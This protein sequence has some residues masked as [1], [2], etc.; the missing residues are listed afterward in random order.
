MSRRRYAVVGSGVSGLV[1]A[2]VLSRTGDVTLFEADARL[3]GHADTHDVEVGGRMLAVDTGFIVHN[4]RTYP[5]L[6]RLFAELG[7]ATQETDMSMSVRSDADGIEYAGGRGLSGILPSARLIGRPRYLRMLGEVSRFHRAAKA[8]LAQGDSGADLAAFLDEHS[9]SADF[10]RWFMT[11]LVAAVWS[12]DPADAGDYPAR[13]LFTFLEHHGMLGVLG[14]P[15]WRTVV[16]GSRTYVDAVAARMADVRLSTP[17]RSVED[18]GLGVVVTTDAGREAFDGVVLAVHAPTALSLLPHATDAQRRVLGAF[19]YSPNVARLHTDESLLPRNPRARASWNY[20]VPDTDRAGEVVVTYDMTRLQRLTAAGDTR[21]LVTLGGED[22]IDPDKVLATMDYE[23]PL[24]TAESVAAQAQVPSVESDRLAFAGAWR[25]WG[26]HEDGALSGLR[27]AERLGG[28]WDAGDEEPSAPDIL[29]RIYEV[30]VSHARREPVRHDFT[31]R[32]ATW[33]VDLDHLPNHGALARFE[34]RDHVGDP[35]ASIRSNIEAFLAAHDIDL[36]GGRVRMLAQPRVLGY[37]FNPISVHWC[38]DRDGSLA[39][40]VVEVHNTYGDRHAYLVHPDAAGDAH[41]D[42]ALYVSPFNDVSGS[43]RVHVPEPGERVHLAITLER[44]GEPPFVATMR[45]NAVPATLRNVRRLALRYPAAP[46][47]VSARIHRHGIDLWRKGVRVVDRPV[48]EAQ[49]GLADPVVP[50]VDPAV[51]LERWPDLRPVPPS[52]VSQVARRISSGVLRRLAATAGIRVTMP[53][54][55]AFGSTAP[56]A[57]VLRVVR[58]ESFHARVGRDGLIGFGEAW[59]A[60]DWRSDDLAGLLTVLARRIDRIVPDSW[61]RL[62]ALYV[63]RHPAAEIGTE[64]NTRNNIARHYDLSND[65]FASFLDSTMTYSSAWFPQHDVEGGQRPGWSDLEKAQTAKIDRILDRLDVQPG[66]RLLEI[67]TGWG[68]LAIR[69]ARR[70]ATVR[71]ITQS[72]EQRGLA[73]DRV[74]QLGLDDAV[75]V[76]LLDYRAVE[77]E[78]DRVVSVE[79]IEA[80]GLDYLPTYFET[81][82]RVLAPGGRAAIQAIT[83]ADQRMLATRDTFTWVHK[84]IFPGGLI[85]SVEAIER[86]CAATALRLRE[87]FRFGR[88]YAETLRLWEERFLDAWPRIEPLGFDETFRRMWQFYL[89]YSRAGFASGYLDVRHLVL[90][91][92]ES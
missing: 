40:V 19:R 84:Y 43:Y 8:V 54:G 5:T 6:L 17:V 47:V 3:G 28:S 29:P 14:S 12:C 68:E 20:L 11:P 77:G 35:A 63:A 61:Q 76:D 60:G 1:A 25:G 80:V 32:T 4:D 38:H 51:D 79:M 46:L 23:H 18:Y 36:R 37:C 52:V 34:A 66:T 91:K 49:R 92:V 72:A 45:G 59:M 73:L 89:A 39:A 53:D 65:L 56:N 24:F 78:Y 87:D 9:F 74:R 21:L 58:P 15:P 44:E 64:A 30:A 50:V 7:T 86:A 75:T 67:G 83:M 31:H 10:R 62:R 69:A 57:P 26:F 88:H 27:A 81:I 41:V 82:D 22:L 16:G 13:H 33:L 90:H 85:P 71:S 2:H 48:H 55:S 70:G 42:K